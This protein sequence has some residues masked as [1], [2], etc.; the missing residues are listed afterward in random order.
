M[1]PSVKWLL[2]KHEDVALIPSTYIKKLGVVACACDLSSGKAETGGI[3]GV[4]Q[5]SLIGKPKCLRNHASAGHGG[6]R[7]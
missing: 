7:L 4:R 1:A 2:R 3:P 6:A 5:L